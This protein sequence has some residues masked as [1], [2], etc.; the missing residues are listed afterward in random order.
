MVPEYLAFSLTDYRPA[1][2]ISGCQPWKYELKSL[3]IRW[4][5]LHSLSSI[6]K[7]SNHPTKLQP[8]ECSL[9]VLCAIYEGLS[10]CLWASNPFNP[11]RTCTKV[12]FIS[13]EKSQ[14]VSWLMDWFKDSISTHSQQME[15]VQFVDISFFLCHFCWIYQRV[16]SRVYWQFEC[17]TSVMKVSTPLCLWPWHPA[18]K[19]C[20]THCRIVTNC[21]PK[22]SSSNI[23]GW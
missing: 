12:G 1:N 23:W 10:L 2:I 22:W 3:K 16:N 13:L 5:F 6:S 15:S 7:I 8:W 20:N 21:C 9:H 17:E 18:R 14:A 11:G 4:F 19:Q